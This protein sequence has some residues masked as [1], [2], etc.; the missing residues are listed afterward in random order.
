MIDQLKHC[1]LLVQPCNTGNWILHLSLHFLLMLFAFWIRNSNYCYS[2]R[3]LFSLQYWN[4]EFSLWPTLRFQ[5]VNLNKN[6]RENWLP[7]CSQTSLILAYVCTNTILFHICASSSSLSSNSCNRSLHSGLMHKGLTLLKSRI[8]WFVETFFV[9]FFFFFFSVF[10]A[11]AFPSAI[12]ISAPLSSR[13][14]SNSCFAGGFVLALWFCG[15]PAA[16]TAA[17]NICSLFWK[18]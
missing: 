10:W 6:D 8:P 7:I 16:I 5:K 9:S 18:L 14:S 13:L 17:W 2:Q 1:F 15:S 11:A 3:A 4:H 12:R